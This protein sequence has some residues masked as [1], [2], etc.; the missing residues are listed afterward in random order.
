MSPP[1][2]AAPPLTLIIYTVSAELTLQPAVLVAAVTRAAF[3]DGWLMYPSS[4]AWDCAACA[5]ATDPTHPSYAWA[6]N[7]R[8]DYLRQGLSS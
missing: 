6:V 5:A 7:A 8:A 2:A 4:E 3:L 1:P